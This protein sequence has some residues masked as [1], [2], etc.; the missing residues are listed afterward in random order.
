MSDEKKFPQN[1]RYH[2]PKCQWPMENVLSKYVSKEGNFEFLHCINCGQDFYREPTEIIMSP[3]G[4]I[5]QII[6]KRIEVE[7]DYIIKPQKYIKRK[8]PVSIKRF[9]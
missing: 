1:K 2:C 5:E 8:L 9:N 3:K 7:L 4:H 6:L